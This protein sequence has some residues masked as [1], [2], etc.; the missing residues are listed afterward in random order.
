MEFA[1]L[2]EAMARVPGPVVVVT[3]V[4]GTER[5]FGFTASS[6]V[7][8]SLEPPLILVCLGK[9]AST[10]PAFQAAN[11][12]MVNV[13][14]EGQEEVAR[15]FSTS[16]V[17]RFAASDMMPC[18]LG[19]PGLPDAVARVACSMH[20]IVDAGDHSILIGQVESVYVGNRSPLVYANRLFSR[21]ESPALARDAR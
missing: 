11:T 4:D 15:R 21:V 12:F 5:R 8:V 6:F 1:I 19:L 10:H 3:M 9:E 7:S 14:A 2:K 17:D 18:E 20:R 13:L 16:G